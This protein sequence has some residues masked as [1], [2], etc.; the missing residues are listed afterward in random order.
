MSGKAESSDQNLCPAKVIQEGKWSKL[1]Q[2][3]HT[4]IMLWVEGTNSEET[5]FL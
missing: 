1:P 3:N 5:F 4:F 2:K